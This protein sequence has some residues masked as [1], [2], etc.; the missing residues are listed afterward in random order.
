VT[1]RRFNVSRDIHFQQVCLGTA[2][3]LDVEQ[4]FGIMWPPYFKLSKSH[5]SVR[6]I[7]FILSQH[8]KEQF[9]VSPEGQRNKNQGTTMFRPVRHC[10]K[11]VSATDSKESCVL[12]KVHISNININEGKT[13][14]ISSPAKK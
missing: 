4:A 2:V 8:S 14:A 10:I 3:I 12:R 1:A 11:C 9:V 5:F 7:K 13:Q 6:I